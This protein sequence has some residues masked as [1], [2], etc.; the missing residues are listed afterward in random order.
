[1]FYVPPEAKVYARTIGGLCRLA[2]DWLNTHPPEQRILPAW[3]LDLLC[4]LVL[5]SPPILAKMMG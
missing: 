3:P 2:Q 1:M 5:L 4:G